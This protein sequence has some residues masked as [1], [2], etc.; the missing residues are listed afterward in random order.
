V[1]EEG[2]YLERHVF[3]TDVECVKMG[4]LSG[5]FARTGQSAFNLFVPRA[6]R[7]LGIRRRTMPVSMMQNFSA[8]D[9]ESGCGGDAAIATVAEGVGSGSASRPLQN[10]IGRLW[11]IRSDS[12]SHV[13]FTRTRFWR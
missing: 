5:C 10:A 3:T 7:Y 8:V 13:P 12:I 9:G 6:R 1:I 2:T 4:C 11:V